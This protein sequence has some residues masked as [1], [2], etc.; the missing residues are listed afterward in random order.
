MM[1]S[2][3]SILLVAHGA[4]SSGEAE[5]AARD[6]ARR[7]AASGRYREVSLCF[8]SNEEV[9]PTL[10]PGDVFIVPLFMSR[11]YFVETR[12][13]ALFGLDSGALVRR[14]HLRTDAAGRLFFC[15]AIGED[16]MLAGIL[17]AMGRE[18]AAAMN[19]AASDLHIL[20][21]AHGSASSSASREAAEQQRQALVEGREFAAVSL[22]YLS[23]PPHLAVWLR[24]EGARGAH[25]AA[26]AAIGVFAANG[27][28]AGEE[29]PAILESW[30]EESGTAR[31][32]SYL[33]AVGARPEI[34]DLIERSIARA[35]AAMMWDGGL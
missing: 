9:A 12:I 15:E 5:A 10:P 30:R 1:P 27:P 18:A 17:A 6:H 21:I 2:R 4:T 25:G 7:L 19:V 33:G 35:A 14:V 8:L 32:I 31:R 20:L 26:L 28:H 34:T 22:T 23:E 29:I 16:P 11:G 3:P 13:P 24:E